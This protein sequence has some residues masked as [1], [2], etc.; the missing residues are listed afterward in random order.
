MFRNSERNIGESGSLINH[1]SEIC[2]N[3]KLVFLM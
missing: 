3:N 2:V 1:N